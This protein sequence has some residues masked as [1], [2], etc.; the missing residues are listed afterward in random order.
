MT[1][2]SK[3]LEKK[4]DGMTNEKKRKTVLEQ[5]ENI[6][7][8]HNKLAIATQQIFDA[9]QKDIN[10]VA[11]T[12]AAIVKVVGV[13]AVNTEVNKINIEN[14]EKTSADNAK[15]VEDALANGSLEVL[16]VI[17]KNLNSLV[18]GQIKDKDGVVVHP[19]KTY[20]HLHQYKPE[21]I[22]RLVGKKVGD[23]LDLEDGNVLTV[24]ESYIEVKGQEPVSK[25]LN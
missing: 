14:M 11:T 17:D 8:N 22:E 7:E 16:E 21:F 5:V 9:I 10:N 4:Q 3:K 1:K 12:L 19:S 2:L 15:L 13:D 25:D 20:V 18:V 23:T 24:L 6:I